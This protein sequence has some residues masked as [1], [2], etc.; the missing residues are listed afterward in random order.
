MT[1]NAPSSATSFAW[2]EIKVNVHARASRTRGAGLCRAG[3]DIVS[4]RALA[5][6][7]PIS[8]DLDSR[9]C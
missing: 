5:L 4:A 9:L 6:R 8:L 1:A 3:A 2:P 7:S